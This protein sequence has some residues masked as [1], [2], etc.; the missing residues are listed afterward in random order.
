M[1]ITWGPSGLHYLVTPAAGDS[2]KPFYITSDDWEVGDTIRI[3]T[4]RMEGGEGLVSYKAIIQSVE[5]DVLLVPLGGSIWRMDFRYT[6]YPG[7]SGYAAGTDVVID[8]KVTGDDPSTY[9]ASDNYGATSY[10]MCS[11]TTDPVPAD[12]ADPVAL[13]TDT[14]TFDCANFDP[15]ATPYQARLWKNGTPQGFSSQLSGKSYDI[16][17]HTP[18]TDGAVYTWRIDTNIDIAS[19]IIGN[20]WT[21]TAGTPL[22]DKATNPS[23][24]NTATGVTLDHPALTWTEGSGADY[25]QV[26]FG[27][28]GN[29]SL[30]DA[31][32]TDQSFSLAS[33]LPFPYNT[34]YQWRIDSTND[35]GTT[36]GDTWSFTTLVFA[37]PDGGGGPGAAGVG[38]FQ[39]IKRLCACAENRFWYEDV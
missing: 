24:A 23:P 33:Y 12:D 31:N 10:L 28:T 35:S 9:L 37:P 13:D 21:F 30:V 3:A 36:T 26:Y 14:L 34:T 18:L 6:D 15:G 19:D 39:I 38:D 25:E 4:F 20:I 2:A 17:S 16:S 11:Q 5:Y 1:G 32:D 8:A 27:L 29:M 22:P 7:W